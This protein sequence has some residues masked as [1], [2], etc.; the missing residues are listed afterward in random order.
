M[1]QDIKFSDPDFTI[2]VKRETIIVFFQPLP[3]GQDVGT[4]GG[5]SQMGSSQAWET[6]DQ[7]SGSVSITKFFC[8][9]I[10]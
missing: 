9:L 3:P 8:I 4:G 10:K 5:T 7:G 1:I 2:L 6:R